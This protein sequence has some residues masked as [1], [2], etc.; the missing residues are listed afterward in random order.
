[1][2]SYCWTCKKSTESVNPI[3]SKTGNGKAMTLSKYGTC[4]SKK[5]RFIKKKKK[6]YLLV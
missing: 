1:M 2:P 4:G 6:Y 5:S 3:I